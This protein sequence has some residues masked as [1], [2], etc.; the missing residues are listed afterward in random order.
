[1]PSRGSLALVLVVG[2]ALAVSGCAPASVPDPALVALVQESLSATRAAQLDLGFVEDDR[3]LGTTSDVVLSD[4]ADA[5]AAAGQELELYTTTSAGDAEYRD[6]ALDAVRDALAGIRTAQEGDPTAG[7]GEVEGA[8]DAL[9][10]LD[11]AGGET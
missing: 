8:A 1:M 5:L 9:A 6:A 2:A 3:V 11:D 4:M 10:E 7:L